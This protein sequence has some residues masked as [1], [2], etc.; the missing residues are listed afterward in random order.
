LLRA[1]TGTETPHWIDRATAEEE[2]GAQPIAYLG[3]PVSAGEV[4]GVMRFVNPI[5]APDSGFTTYDE[6]V[7]KA[8]AS[9]LALQLQQQRSD[10]RTTAIRNLFEVFWRL[11]RTHDR[12]RFL[13]RKAF[14]ALGDAI[15]ECS[16]G[17]RLADEVVLLDGTRRLAMRRLA[18]TDP[19]WN[20]ITPL[21]RHDPASLSMRCFQELEIIDEANRQ[22]AK[23]FT[24]LSET[25]RREYGHFF[26]CRLGKGAGVLHVTR[27]KQG[28]LFTES[29]RQFVCRLGGMLGPVMKKIAEDEQAYLE[30]GILKRL[31]HPSGCGNLTSCL[32]QV[33]SDLEI[34]LQS[35]WSG[36]WLRQGDEFVLHGLHGRRRPGPRLP[37]PTVRAIVGP[38][39][40]CIVNDLEEEVPRTVLRELLPASAGVPEAWPR[41]DRAALP[42]RGANG[43]P[44]A[45][46]VFVAR[47]RETMS[48]RQLEQ[49]T[50][51]LKCLSAVVEKRWAEETG[52]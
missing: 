9:R 2:F 27:K 44:L 52:A 4:H 22:Q 51:F 45:V 7:A 12:Q 41:R 36:V 11:P 25:I 14:K 3:V 26:M 40:P 23:F 29:D 50:E 28:H 42:L 32:A 33:L 24:E 18:C 8:A 10:K 15:G 39:G 20:Q 30:K 5:A 49:I 37:L 6:Q 47:E 31:I 46:F 43:D 17:I 48:F 13:A 21:Y 16:C 19:Q 1:G 35:E 34:L 38:T